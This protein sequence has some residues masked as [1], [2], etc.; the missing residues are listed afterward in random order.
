MNPL[1]MICV[2]HDVNDDVDVCDEV[3]DEVIS[4]LTNCG[5]RFPVELAPPPKSYFACPMIRRSDAAQRLGTDSKIGG[6]R[7][8]P[9]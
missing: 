1:H 5:M 3:D 7:R 6:R 8:N 2:E 4:R 9:F